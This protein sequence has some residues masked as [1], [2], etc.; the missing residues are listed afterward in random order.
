[1]V[2]ISVNGLPKAMKDLIGSMKN[3]N[4]HLFGTKVR[5]DERS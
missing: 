3:S 1:M 4:N 5:G 2:D